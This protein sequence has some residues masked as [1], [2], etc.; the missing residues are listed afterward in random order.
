MGHPALRSARLSLGVAACGGD[1]EGESGG[2]GGESGTAA[3]GKQGGKLTMLVDRRRRLHRSRPDVLPDGPRSSRTQ[4]RSRC[5]AT[6]PTIPT[7]P[8]EDLA[9]GKP[10]VS[11]D[12]KTVTVKIK[13]GVKFSPPVDREVTSKDVKYAIERGLLQHGQQRLRRRRTSATSSAPRLAVKPGT[14]IA[15]IETPDDL[16][17]V[18]KLKRATGRR[19]RRGALVLPLTAPVPE[20]YAQQVRQGEA[21]APTA[22]TRSR[23]VPYMI[24]NNA[25]GKAIGYEATK[26]IHLVRNPNWDKALGFRPAYLDEIDMPQGNDDTTVASRKILDGQRPGHRRLRRPAGHPQAGAHEQQGPAQVRSRAAAAAG[27]R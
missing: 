5:T 23:R 15:G 16:T 9:E 13:K 17:L 3:E 14:K 18:F 1:D 6:S 4:R 24:E 11:E 27:S 22:R 19:P 21:D 25:A 2:G 26:R 20:E 12:G 8:V 7:T 10:E